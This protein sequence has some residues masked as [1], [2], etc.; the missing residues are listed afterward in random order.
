M[1]FFTIKYV[2]VISFLLIDPVYNAPK[3]RNKDHSST[4]FDQKQ[5]GDYNVQVHLK[6]FHIFAVLGDDSW[7]SLGDYDY[8]YD[9]SDLTV[10]PTGSSTSEQPPSSSSSLPPASSIADTEK[11]QLASST[12]LPE[13]SSTIK[14]N[15]DVT[16]PQSST[17]SLSST[18]PKPID[19]TTKS[20]PVTNISLIPV[21]IIGDIDGDHPLPLGEILHYRKCTDGYSRDAQGRCRKIVRKNSQLP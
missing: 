2:C 17:A 14:V 5:T 18:T 13:V 16:E 1:K 12:K 11:P 3:H 15:S 10:K 8:N 9:Y 20:E 21:K 6:D 7:G 4:T 19:K